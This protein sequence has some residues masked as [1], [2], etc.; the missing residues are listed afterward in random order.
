MT[1]NTR[2]T[3][4]ASQQRSRR[5]KTKVSKARS[6]FEHWAKKKDN[7]QPNN[8]EQIDNDV[9]NNSE[10]EIESIC[11]ESPNDN[12][13]VNETAAQRRRYRHRALI[14]SDTIGSIVKGAFTRGTLKSDFEITSIDYILTLINN[15]I[16]P[17]TKKFKFFVV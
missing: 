2:G 10:S 17:S 11:G 3:V 1:P 13:I 7:K 5:N 9:N 4:R 16:Q 15:E 8:N 14:T 12:S 6:R